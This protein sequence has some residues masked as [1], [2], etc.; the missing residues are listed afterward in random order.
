MNPQLSYVEETKKSELPAK[1]YAIDVLGDISARL[2]KRTG[3]S[4]ADPLL[5]KWTRKLPSS[6]DIVSSCCA[7]SGCE[8][9]AIES[10]QLLWGGIKSICEWLNSAKVE[11]KA[12][13]SSKVVYL[14]Q[15]IALAF[16]AIDSTLLLPDAAPASTV[17]T[18][19]IV[20]QMTLAEKVRAYVRALAQQICEVLEDADMRS[21]K[22]LL[23]PA[24]Y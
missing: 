20:K 6:L 13:E 17:S 7:T 14:A 3:F 12:L 4:N 11:D 2:K 16:P 9:A 18:D 15:W 1:T 10:S 23:P 8:D 21:V 5:S 19:D 22:I 24:F